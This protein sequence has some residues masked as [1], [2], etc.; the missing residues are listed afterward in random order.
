MI[1]IAAGKDYNVGQ[2]SRNRYKNVVKYF[3]TMLPL[4]SVFQVKGTCKS[5]VKGKEAPSPTNPSHLN[6]G[7]CFT[8]KTKP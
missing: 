8:T 7:A 1:K 6:R 3:P 4:Y 2:R 5:L